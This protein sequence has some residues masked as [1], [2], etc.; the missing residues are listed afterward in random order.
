MF[1]TR[2][3]RTPGGRLVQGQRSDQGLRQ[4][5]AAGQ[6]RLPGPH[7]GRCRHAAGPRRRRQPAR[8][9]PGERGPVHQHRLSR[10]R[11]AVFRLFRAVPRRPGGPVQPRERRPGLGPDRPG[12]RQDRSRIEVNRE[13]QKRRQLSVCPSVAAV[14]KASDSISL[15]AAW[16]LASRQRAPPWLVATR[17]AKS[18]AGAIQIVA[19]QLVLLPLCVRVRPPA[20][21]R[22][23]DEPA[24]GVVATW[25]GRMQ[26]PE[27]GRLQTAWP[28]PAAPRKVQGGELGPVGHGAM[29]GAGRPHAP[30]RCLAGS[31]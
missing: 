31:A 18:R 24:A 16:S 20:Q 8:Q 13:P 17:M 25:R 4:D 21:E 12:K 10:A 5:P 1:A 26:G 30:A 28:F 15:P 14:R 7:P 3:A 6:G 9:G 27:R 22:S 11:S 29:H 23:A 2:R 19:Y